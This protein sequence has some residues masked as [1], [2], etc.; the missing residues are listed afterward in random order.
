[1]HELI[2]QAFGTVK[3]Q[4]EQK[5]INLII[6]YQANITD[7]QSKLYGLQLSTI[8]I[9]DCFKNFKGD[10]LRYMQI[11]LNFLSNA[12]KFTQDGKNIT[13]RVI[14]LEVQMMNDSSQKQH[15]S[16]LKDLIDNH[17]GPNNSYI[18]FVIQIED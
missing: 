14:L 13:I 1:M 3:Y 16:N 12:I 9:R 18:K 7:T 4:A 17:V 5:K 2:N 15:D 8:E 11:L 10:R 6:D